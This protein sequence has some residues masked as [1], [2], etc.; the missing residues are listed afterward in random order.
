MDNQQPSNKTEWRQVI[1]HPNY[2]VNELG[3]IRHKKK[4]ANSIPEKQ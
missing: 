1:E 4:K 3:Q 2:E